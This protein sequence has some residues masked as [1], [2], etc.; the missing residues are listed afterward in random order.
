MGQIQREVYVLL[1]KLVEVLSRFDKGFR[2]GLE[3]EQRLVIRRP[4]AVI[5]L[6]QMNGEG[7][8]RKA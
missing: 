2:A 4:E 7:K 6:D 5:V 3:G 1:R 8:F